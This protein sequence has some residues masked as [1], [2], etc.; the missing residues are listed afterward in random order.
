MINP[1]NVGKY[2]QELPGKSC[3]HEIFYQIVKQKFPITFLH[4]FAKSCGLSV[5][6]A[7][8]QFISLTSENWNSAKSHRFYVKIFEPRFSISL[9]QSL[10]IKQY[11]ATVWLMLKFSYYYCRYHVYYLKNLNFSQVKLTSNTDVNNWAL[12]VNV[13]GKLLLKVSPYSR[14]WWFHRYFKYILDL[15]DK[16]LEKL[17]TMSLSTLFHFFRSKRLCKS[18]DF[19]L[20]KNHYVCMYAG[21]YICQLKAF[22]STSTRTF[23]F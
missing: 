22:F 6:L 23:C 7:N 17:A 4:I 10:F 8:L 1:K 9:H 16:V 15:M 14:A 12:L 13:S 20:F 19:R 3:S 11:S 2:F 18:K 5:R 21:L